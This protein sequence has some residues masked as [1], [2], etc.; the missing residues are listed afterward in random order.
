MVCG[1][2]VEFH[3]ENF[4]QVENR[5]SAPLHHFTFLPR[6]PS[7][8]VECWPRSKAEK[9]TRVK[10]K[11]KISVIP[12]SRSC[13]VRPDFGI[14]HSRNQLGGTQSQKQLED[15]ERSKASLT[16]LAVRQLA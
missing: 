7:F 14:P 15:P 10:G 9:L 5:K 6:A 1:T 16:R 13:L 12:P 11:A 3:F 4:W 2:E 8:Q